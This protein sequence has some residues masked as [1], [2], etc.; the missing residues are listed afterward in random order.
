ME[1]F[2]NTF[3]TLRSCT[4]LNTAYGGL[5]HNKLF[6]YRHAQDLEFLREGSTMRTNHPAFFD[7]VRSTIAKFTT[8]IKGDVVL[9]QNFS[10]GFRTL[11]SGMDK[12][13][14][15]LL[16]DTDY[17]S[18]NHPVLTN[19]FRTCF[20]KCDENLEKNIKIAIQNHRPDILAMSIVNYQNGLLI[21]LNFIKELKILHPEILIIMDATQFIGT[22]DFD[23]DNSGIDIL[24]TSGYKWLLGGYGNG[25]FLFRKGILDKYTPDLYKENAK[26]SSYP[27]GFTNLYSQFEPGHLD[28]LSFGSLQHSLLY[29]QTLGLPNIQKKISALTSYAKSQL[30][31]ENLLDSAILSRND[32]SSIFTIKGD[33]K[34]YNFLCK[35]GIITSQRGSGI[36]ISLHFYNDHEDIDHLI[37]ILKMV[38]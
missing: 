23:F 32:H 4:Y 37:K 27:S 11:L 8:T 29:L 3:P 34:S 5:L 19:G 12:N 10:L 2:K 35:N 22:R 6:E 15:I 33:Q 26:T 30:L 9:S 18:I 16:M 21:D 25:F 24:G 36:R 38:S 1:N 14:K 17:P 7:E 28:L 31:R 13:Q 20:A